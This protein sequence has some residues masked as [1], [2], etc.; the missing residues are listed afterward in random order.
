MAALFNIEEEE[1]PK[2]PRGHVRAKRKPRRSYEALTA[3]SGGE[4]SAA[5]MSSL[6]AASKQSA[7]IEK[8]DRMNPRDPQLVE[9]AR[10]V[11]STQPRSLE[12]VCHRSNDVYII[13][14]GGAR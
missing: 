1:L 8:F 14:S 13:T 2:G 6:D 7:Y 10:N 3:E 5:D 4:E 12:E 11:A 9:I